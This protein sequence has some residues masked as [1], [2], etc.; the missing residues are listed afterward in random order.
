MQG[1]ILFA[2]AALI[3]ALPGLDC[4]LPLPKLGLILLLLVVLLSWGGLHRLSWPE[5]VVL[6]R[7]VLIPSQLMVVGGVVVSFV[8]PMAFSRYFVVL[9]PAVLPVLPVQFSALN[10]NRLGRGCCIGVLGLLLAS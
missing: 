7:S 5:P 9:V 2:L 6:D 8:K 3:A 1:R 4:Y 10:L